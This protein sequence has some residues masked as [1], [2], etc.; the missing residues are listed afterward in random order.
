MSLSV[1]SLRGFLSFSLSLSPSLSL[2]SERQ[3]DRE[4]QRQRDRKT[5]RER[6]RETDR[7]KT[8]RQTDRQRDR[9]TEGQKDKEIPVGP[10]MA[11]PSGFE[12]H[13]NFCGNRL[14]ARG[15]RVGGPRQTSFQRVFLELLKSDVLEFNRGLSRSTRKREPRI[16]CAPQ[17][18]VP[19]RV[20]HREPP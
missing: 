4:T 1:S 19:K 17:R 13:G 11:A 7:Q 18:D 9:G 8:A 10:S 16:D 5:K 20:R 14:M 2:G 3:R 6:D 15:T 12:G